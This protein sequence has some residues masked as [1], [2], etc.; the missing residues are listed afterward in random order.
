M[1]QLCMRTF[2]ECTLKNI[3]SSLKNKFARWIAVAYF[4]INVVP[5]RNHSVYLYQRCMFLNNKFY[6]VI[7]LKQKFWRK[8]L[9]N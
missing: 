1:F 7:D 3:L 9:V 5:K 8:K 2:D 6:T 4:Y